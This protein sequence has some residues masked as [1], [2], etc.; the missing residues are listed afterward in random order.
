[1]SIKKHVHLS[2][3]KN[4]IKNILKVQN[5]FFLNNFRMLTG[6]KF[7]RLKHGMKA[8]IVVTNSISGP[9]DWPLCP[10]CNMRKQCYHGESGLCSDC[11]EKRQVE[12]VLDRGEQVKKLHQMDTW[13]DN[14]ISELFWQHL[15]RYQKEPN[16]R[17]LEIMEL[18]FYWA[19]HENH[20]FC[21]SISHA[22]EWCGI[23]II[24]ERQRL[25]NE[26]T[27]DT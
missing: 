26:V 24:A 6:R 1:M 8:S 11:H 23:S 3:G 7:R 5:K 10:V 2:G 13:S 4:E 14:D 18:V 9:Q 25:Q 27:A 17:S 19:K 16:L 12:A 20:A 22:M 15:I 21:N